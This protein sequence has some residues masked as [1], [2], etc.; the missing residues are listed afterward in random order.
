MTTT[1]EEVF[2]FPASFAQRRVWFLGQLEP[3]SAAHNMPLPLSWR[4][5]VDGE[6]LERT[7]NELV[8]RHEALRTTFDAVDGEP[9]QLIAPRLHLPVPLVDLSGLPEGARERE[10]E[11]LAAIEAQR[12]FDL[13]RGPLMRAEL[14][15]KGPAD[16][17]L[18]LTLH[19]IIADGWSIAILLRE[20]EEIYRAFVSRQPSPLPEPRL[21]YA[22]FADWQRQRISGALLDEHLSYWR[23]QL[24]GAPTLLPLPTD[25]PRPSRQ[26]YRGAAHP[27]S[28]PL[29]LAEALVAF[30]REMGATPFMTLLAGWMALLGRYSGCDDVVVGTPIANRTRPEVEGVIGLFVNMLVLRGELSGDPSLRTL[31][32]RVRETTLGAYEHQDLPFERLVEELQPERSLAHNPL[33]QVLFVLQNLPGLAT[34]DDGPAIQTGTAKFDLT[35]SLGA[36]ASGFAGALEYNTDLFDATTIARMARQLVVLL[37]GALAAPD[38]P[39]STLALGASAVAT[40]RSR[41]AE[42]VLQR[43]AAQVAERPHAIALTIGERRLTYR[44]LHARSA[45][46]AE[47]LRTTVTPSTPV[48]LCL[49]EPDAAVVALLGALSAGAVAL[50]LGADDRCARL[51]AI[52]ADAGAPLVLTEAALRERFDGVRATVWTLDGQEAPSADL[53]AALP[54]LEAPALRLY[55]SGASGGPEARAFTHA[56][57][58]RTALDARPGERVALLSPLFGE[59]ALLELFTALAHGGELVWLRA[60]PEVTPRELSVELRRARAQILFLDGAALGPLVEAE[61]TVLAGMR[62]YVVGQAPDAVTVARVRRAGEPAQ[63]TQMYLPVELLGPCAQADVDGFGRTGVVVGTP[64]DDT[65][66][67]VLDRGGRPAPLGVPGAVHVTRGHRFATG[68]RGRLLDD[69]RLELLDRAD[70]RLRIAGTLVEPAEVEAVLRRHP[71]LRDA[72]VV[73]RVVLSDERL[74]AYLV[75]GNEAPTVAEV[76]AFV[77]ERLPDALTPA[78]FVFV[79]ALPRRGGQVDARALPPVETDRPEVGAFVAPE[80]A[81]EQRLAAIWARLF[82]LERVGRH[83]NFFQLGGHSLLAMQVIARAGDTFGVELPLR[84]LFQTPTVAGLARA[85]EELLARAPGRGAPTL[86]PELRGD[87]IPLSFAQERLWFLEQLEPGTPTYN[88]A[89]TLRLQGGLDVDALARSLAEIVRRHEVLRTRFAA[90]DGRPIQVIAPPPPPS[91]P[92]IDLAALP[93]PAREAEAQRIARREALRPFDLATGPL[94][95]WLLVDLSPTDRLLLLTVHHIVSDGWSTGVLGRELDTL[96]RAFATGQPSPLPELRLQYADF[97]I[98]QRRWLHGDVLERQLAY[99]RAQLAS[100]PPLLELPADH[101]RP[102]VESHRGACVYYLLP[103]TLS[104]ALKRLAQREGATLFMTLLGGFAV[105]LQ[106]YSGQADL[107]VGTPVANRTQAQLEGLIGF[108]ANTLALRLD[109]GGDPSFRQLLARVRETTLDAFAQPDLPFEKLVEELRPE[110]QLGYHPLFQVMFILQN[111]GGV[112]PGGAVPVGATPAIVETSAKFDLTLSMAECADGLL[113]AFEFNTDLFQPDR[114]ARMA[115]HL[116][117]LLGGI[118]AAPDQPLSRLPLLDGDERR[119]LLREWNATDRHEPPL[120]LVHEAVAAQAARTPERIAVRHAEGT[121]SYRQLDQQA[122]Q[123]AWRL[124][125]LGVTSETPVAIAATR[126]PRLLVGLLGILKAGGAYVP[127]DPSYPRERLAFMLDDAG[128]ELA[129]SERTCADL[130]PGR[131]IVLLDDELG[132]AAAPPPGQT[133]LGQVAYVLYTSGS[134]G[135]PKGVAITH[136]SVAELLRWAHVTFDADDLERVLATTSICFDLSVFELFA[137]LARGGTVILCADALTLGPGAAEATL[138]NTVPSIAAE[139]VRAGSWPAGLRVIN[140]AGEPLPTALASTLGAR[141]PA[142]RLYNLYGPSEDTTYSTCA[143]VGDTDPPPIGAPI[144]NTRAY[145]LDPV[146]EPAPIGVPGE[147]Y[148]GGAG[149]A[150]GYHRRAALTAERFVPDPYGGPGERLYRT[151]DLARWR[152]DGQLEYLGRIDQQVKLRGFRIEL[153]E[154]ETLLRA[155]PSVADAAVTCLREAQQLAAYVVPATGALVPGELRAWLAERLPRYMVP[156]W[157][158]PLTALPR[159]PSGKL[160]RRRLPRPDGEPAP[161]PSHEPHTPTEALLAR[162]FAAVLGREQVGRDDD[163]FELGGHSLLATQVAS[164]VRAE[165]GRELPLK[166][167]FDSPTVARLAA[168]LDDASP[169]EAHATTALDTPPATTAL[170]PAP[171]SFA[172]RR[173]WFLD[174]LEPGSAAYILPLQLRLPVP[175]DATI[176]ERAL[177]EIVRRHGSLRTRFVVEAGEPVQ[178]VAPHLPLP[179]A[180]E[181]LTE[182]APEARTAELEQ[183]ARDE[184]QRPFDLSRGPLLRCRLI[185]LAPEDHALLLT[186]HHIITDGW[187]MTVLVRELDTLYRAFAAGQPSPLPAL[188]LQY[189]DYATQEREVL[190]GERLRQKLDFWTRALAGAP[191]LLAL[192][193]ERPRSSGRRGAAQ[194]IALATELTAALKTLARQERVSLFMLLLAALHTLLARESG[195]SDVLVGT[196][197]ANRERPELES[198]IGLF[199]N[200]IVLRASLADRPPFRELLAQVRETTLAAFA[201]QDLPFERLVEALQPERSLV[202]HPLFQVMFVLQN[203]PGSGGGAPPIGNGSAKY[204]LTLML[205]EGPDGLCGQLEYN[206]ELFDAGAAARLVAHFEVLLRAIVA[207]PNARVTQ[208]PLLTAGEAAQLVVWNETAVARPECTL[209]GLFAAQARRTPHAIAVEQGDERLTFAALEAA[210]TRLAQRLRAA[211]VGVEATVAV[212]AER[213]LE[214]VVGLLAILKAGAAYLPLDPAYPAERLAFMCSDSGARL[215]L[216]PARLRHCLSGAAVLELDGCAT[217]EAALPLED[218]VPLDAAAYVIYTSGSTGRP[219][220]VVTSHRGIWNHITWLAERFRIGPADVVLHHTPISF[221]ASVWE[222]F[223]PLAS[224]ARLVLAPPG[225]PSL[226][227][228]VVRHGVTVVQLVPSL[229]RVLVGA[230]ELGRCGSLRRVF[231]GGEPLPVELQ[232]KL[233]AQLDV[234]LINLYG[235]TEA[236]IDVTAHVAA[237]TSTATVPIGL[238]IANMEAHVLDDELALVP[239]GVVGELYAAG[240]GLARGYYRRPSLTAERFIPCPFGPPG[241]RMYRTGDRVRRLADGTLE[242]LGRYDDQ[243]KVRGFRIELGEIEAALAAQPLVVEAAARVEERAPGDQRLLAYVAGPPS[244][245]PSQLRAALAARLPAYMVP[246]QIVIADSLPH[247]PAGKLDRRSLPA[248][249]GPPQREGAPVPARTPLEEALVELWSALLG[250]ASVGVHDD[251]FALGGHSILATQLVAR[252]RE[253]FGITLPLRAVF[254]APTIASLAVAIVDQGLAADESARRLLEELERSP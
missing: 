161:P 91:L 105:L 46:L 10:A 192:P 3:D 8:R 84:R 247:T 43:F 241:S 87:T 178:V 202:H 127:L 103:A 4:A 239:V 81:V 2:A 94:Y 151:G 26:L 253:R 153:G 19:H 240:T 223:V 95:R 228:T 86:G 166:R 96:Y 188:A 76:R 77:R 180:V 63:W 45:W 199:V 134:T 66:L 184:A 119:K 163:F 78:H 140:L 145:V 234:E 146:G 24:A 195:Q 52:V 128:A 205:G 120:A 39:L 49:A 206:S 167:I 60:D 53:V 38:V 243:V 245:S 113:A 22:D 208:L 233:A 177:A 162:I 222:L 207:D 114:I 242:F 111:G 31:V 190:Q 191:P 9:M 59:R 217:P 108:F 131:R 101:P 158:V 186:L 249:D 203:T 175:V 174:Q 141:C 204:D 17:L 55:R 143:R 251:F 42:S 28:L 168:A 61:A 14:V 159:T 250:H 187:S 227:E 64:A 126:S 33:F 89:S 70:R 230:G 237:A 133:R 219:K 185:R 157:I 82:G 171:L 130:L 197:V 32:G 27:L 196:A 40:G 122:N 72:V 68:D 36:S 110:R 225:D 176:L 56:E 74:V 182:L 97:A 29:P 35:L 62:V 16:H 156:A 115:A 125:A 1:D 135:R 252:L 220:G 248:L 34:A 138:I 51:A 218:T 48:A 13:R 92:R 221:D 21:Q 98:W 232:R 198:L 106:R 193:T 117:Q 172:Q 71:G 215:L 44:E 121:L 75:A 69:G 244:L 85:V 41:G 12:P 73:A 67:E 201:H 30:S 132:D 189:T 152:A 210:A 160:D 124:R 90:V 236:S 229:L 147:L 93:P 57:L 37:E 238:P 150:R 79:D 154:I 214:L 224:G 107:L 231:C 5:P 65:T 15:R 99:W 211:G 235:P 183:R 129:L 104:D 109:L 173:L 18:L 116:Q 123:V 181:D 11:R 23:Q 164:R 137:P 179:I 142:A 112:A 83:D 102:S 144:C 118:A 58:G 148:L 226:V 136:G 25:R 54:E 169:S 139:L 200:V 6:A 246:S 216:A 155:H 88:M 100:A 149:L 165:L 20:L 170:R 212:C 213:S 47:R 80:S 194:P 254:E 209:H 50:P 7:L